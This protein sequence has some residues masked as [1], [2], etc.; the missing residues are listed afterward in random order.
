MNSKGFTLSGVLSPQTNQHQR[1]ESIGTI[2][3]TVN[4]INDSKSLVF[5]MKK[6][7]G[8]NRW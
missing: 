8:S 4:S 3:E 6:K 2:D 5:I 7:T 1:T